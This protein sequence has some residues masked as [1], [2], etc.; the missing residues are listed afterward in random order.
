MMD[1]AA[2][3]RYRY[4]VQAPAAECASARERDRAARKGI[5]SLEGPAPG[6]TFRAA[7]RIWRWAWRTRRPE[8]IRRHHRRQP[9]RLDSG[10]HRHPCRPRP[11]SRSLPGRAGR[12]GGLS[13]RLRR[14]Q[15]R[16]RRGRG[17]GRQ[18]A[19]RR[20]RHA[21]VQK[22]V[23]CDPRGMRKY[24]DPRLVDADTLLEAARGPLASRASMTASSTRRAGEDVAIL[25]STSGT[26]SHPK[27]AR[28]TSGAVL[29]HCA[30]YCG[31]DPGPDDEY[32]S[33]LPLAW[34]V[35]QFHVLGNRSCAA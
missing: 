35:E 11:E 8:A 34:I 2:R 13:R 5:R 32:V 3:G 31:L 17:A 4:A 33:V 19:E 30:T 15:A 9:A 16:H 6:P 21:P 1:F 29:R 12:G 10:R 26:T 25:C 23:Y 22:I 7:C 24:N 20:R 14:G 28:L 27:L 18:D